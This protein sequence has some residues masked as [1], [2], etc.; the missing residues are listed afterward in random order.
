M[1]LKP[2]EDMNN[3]N[4]YMDNLVTDQEIRKKYL[5]NNVLHGS[6]F[7]KAVLIAI[8]VLLR[9]YIKTYHIMNFFIIRNVRI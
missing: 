1:K 6:L 8:Y 4:K 2:V 5:K 3:Y 7:A 9:R